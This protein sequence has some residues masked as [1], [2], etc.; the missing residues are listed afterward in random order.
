MDIQTDV[1]NR[2]NRFVGKKVLWFFGMSVLAGVILIAAFGGVMYL[3]VG[4]LIHKT[5]DGSYTSTSQQHFSY[6]TADGGSCN[7]AVIPVDGELFVSSTD[8]N[9]NGGTAGNDVVY[10][11]QYADKDN[12]IKGIVLQVNSPG[13]SGVAGE[14]IAQA[15]K[16]SKKPSVALIQDLGDSAAYFASTGA[17]TIIAS[18]LSDVGDIGVTSSYVDNSGA[19]TKQGDSFIQISAG[20]YKDSGNPDKPLTADEK[21]LLQNNVDIDYNT[22]VNEIAANRNVATSTVLNLANGASVPGSVA[23]KEGLVDTLGNMANAETWIQNRLTDKP[24]IIL[25]Q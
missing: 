21:Q 1:P 12:D 13:G 16:A 17:G 23:V 5:L 20:K 25:C 9:A 2:I 14:M 4:R 10:Q 18:P 3:A 15:L 24:D 8:A 7:V 19:D 6:T 22:L 11:I